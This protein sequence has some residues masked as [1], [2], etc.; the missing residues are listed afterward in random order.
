MPKKTAKFFLWV[1]S[2]FTEDRPKISK[3]V[4]YMTIAFNAS[5]RSIDP[6]TLHGAVLVSKD[7]RI[8]S[9]GYN[10]PVKGC[11][12]S[13]VPRGRPDKYKH[14]LHAEENSI[15]NYYGSYQDI[16]GGTLYVTGLP[17]SNCL[18]M[19]LQKGITRVVYAPIWSKCLDEE[20]ITARDL[21]LEYQ[22]K[23]ITFD[24]MSIKDMEA[25]IKN[26][27]ETILYIQHKTG[28]LK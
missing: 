12:D 24:K 5:R 26:L 7:G 2:F 9:T 18:R 17:C 22:G 3:D 19:T 11:D 8:L 28:M 23:D 6:S 27:D 13:R 20:D 21:M 1:K 16:E 25:V 14:F 10:G 4:Y 15:V